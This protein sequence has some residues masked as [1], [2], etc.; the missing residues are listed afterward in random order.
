MKSQHLRYILSL[1][2]LLASTGLTRAFSP[3]TYTESSALSRGRWVKLSVSHTGLHM[4]SLADLRAWGFDNPSK[5]RI[6]GYGG[7]RISDR[8]TFDN[9]TDDLPMLQSELTSRGIVFY[10]EGPLTPTSDIYG[11][12]F[13]TTNPYSTLGYYFI[14]DNEAEERAIP[15]EGR[16]ATGQPGQYFTATA[17]HETDAVSPAGSGHLMVGED[18]RFTPTR[19][20]TIQLPGREDDSEI[21]MQCV[22]FAK[23]SGGV[24]LTFAENG[25]TLPA[26]TSDRVSGTGDWGEL[27]TMRRTF[28]PT[29]GQ[30]LNLTITA[31]QMGTLT[32][33][34]LDKITV[35]YQRRIALPASH[36]LEFTGFASSLEGAGENTRIWDVTNPLAIVRM[37]HSVTDGIAGWNNDYYGRRTYAAWNENA[38]FLT[39]KVAGV[40]KK[41]RKSVV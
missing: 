30:Q 4:I 2:L 7:K 36:R 17:V 9:Y 33:A 28:V 38:Q 15:V 22:F 19:R 32:Q 1:L 25:N 27:A 34:Y 10:A 35:N 13:Y 3:D 21:T 23:A 40:I 26:S 39:P 31:S 16:P 18:F 12:I 8:F 24:Q 41:D 6:Y 5:V 37:N 14:S 20:F 11:T 29:S